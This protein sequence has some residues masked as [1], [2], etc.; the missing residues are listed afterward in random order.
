MVHNLSDIATTG[1]A[2]ALSLS[3]ITCNYVIISAPTGN[4]A[5]LRIGDSTTSATSGAVV[6]AGLPLTLWPIAD[7][8]YLDLGAIF[9]F[10]SAG[11][12]AS[13]LYGTH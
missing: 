1:A 7:T 10:G 3:H 5:D 2:V 8:K 6:K 11:D 4:A 9:V 13:I 12:H